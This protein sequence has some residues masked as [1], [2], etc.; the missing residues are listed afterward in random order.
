MKT[1]TMCD[2]DTPD[3]W[4]DITAES[5]TEAVAMCLDAERVSFTE[6][7][8]DHPACSTFAA[9]RPSP[10]GGHTKIGCVRV[11]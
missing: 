10:T 7:I 3:K 1:W 11:R 4:F 5:W 2:L 8:N 9:Y 6:P